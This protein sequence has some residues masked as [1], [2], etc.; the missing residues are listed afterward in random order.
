MTDAGN[1]KKLVF[2]KEFPPGCPPEE[3]VSAT[4]VVYR[5]VKNAQLSPGDFLSTQEEGRKFSARFRCQAAGLSVYRDQRD[6]DLCRKKYPRLG[7]R[8][9]QGVLTNEHGKTKPTPNNGNSHTTWWPHDGVV[10][11]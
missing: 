3:A 11:E 10:R 9:A 8:I 4:G 2:P 6:A 1:L 7:E 5:I